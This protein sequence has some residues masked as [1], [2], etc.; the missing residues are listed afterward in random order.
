MC[1]QKDVASLKVY[2]FE[3]VFLNS[4]IIYIYFSSIGEAEREILTLAPHFE[5]KTLPETFDS[6][7]T[8][9][10]QLS[11]EDITWLHLL[12]NISLSNNAFILKK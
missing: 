9:L 10:K 1:F 5:A 2:H 11:Q 12:S 8:R 4:L 3:F 7:L 6:K